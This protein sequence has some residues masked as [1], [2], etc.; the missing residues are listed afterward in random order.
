MDELLPLALYFLKLGTVV[1][2]GPVALIERM[3]RE[4]LEERG[5]ITERDF[6]Q[7]LAMSK[8]AP[9]PIATQLAIY[10]GFI[11]RGVLGATVCG[12]ALIGPSFLMVVALAVLYTR[13]STLWW[14]QGLFYGVGAAVFAIIARS[15]YRLTTRTLGDRK[16]LWAMAAVMAAVTI[17]LRTEPLWLFVAFGL[18]GI[19]I[20]APPKRPA[21]LRL[22]AM[23]PSLGMLAPAGRAP[24][25][26]A[27]LGSIFLFFL[28]SSAIV[29]GG[30][31]A[32]VPFLYGGVVEQYRWLTHQ[33]FVDAVAVAMITPGPVVITVAFIGYLVAGLA[34]AFLAALGVFLP[35]YLI[36]VALTPWYHRH[37]NQPQISAFADGV[38][39]AAIGA[40]IGAVWLIAPDAIR[41]LPTAAIAATSMVLLLTNRV[42]EPALVL[43]SGI[44]GLL[45]FRR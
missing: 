34:G 10:I 28:K 13:E 32:I 11:R 43:L 31:L 3:R 35:V 17:A 44:A 23:L 22:G 40:L 14:M 39:A 27:L 37:G 30:G 1:F 20:Y 5:W 6:V 2:G 16:P 15:G 21:A 42:P 19:L 41:D 25:D 36:V 29:Y 45:L 18:L 9:G 24:A 38:T 12:L 33:Q 26:G 4:L 7:G 8:L